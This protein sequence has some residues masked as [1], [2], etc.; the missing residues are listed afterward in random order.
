MRPRTVM[1]LAVLVA[2]LAAFIWFIER[3]L[4]GSDRRAE[5][6]KRVLAVEPDEVTAVV[7]E[8]GGER[9]RLERVDGR[10]PAGGSS[11]GEDEMEAAGGGLAAASRWA[12]VEPVAAPADA[13]EVDALVSALVELEKERTLDEADDAALGLDL[14][15]ARVV[16]ESASDEHTLLVGGEIPT[17]STMIVAAGDGRFVVSDA[18]W[19]D[20]GR[21]PG[22]WRSREVFDLERDQ[23][24]RVRLES[25]TVSLL[26]AR[27]G[28][29]F[30]IE[31]PE[32]DRAHEDRVSTLLGDLV[33]LE[34]DTFVDEP[35]GPAA[36]LGLE[37]PRATVELVVEGR[38]APLKLE[39]GDPTEDGGGRYARLGARLFE[40]GDELDEALSRPLEEWRSA[41][42][43]SL[44]SWEIDAA[45][46]IDAGGEMALTREGGDW[47]RGEATLE[48]TPV[49]DLL[50]AVT[51]AA[52]ER[53]IDRAE[54]GAELPEPTLELR[55]GGD[56][57]EEILRLHGAW[58]GGFLAS[59]EGRDRLLVLSAGTVDD[60]R[61]KLEGVRE[62]EPEGGD[63]SPEVG[64]TDETDASG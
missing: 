39:L 26:L 32:V 38:E 25:D 11:A 61:M 60:L 44:E 18:L 7:I 4:P 50:Y 12:V 17:S 3:D 22:D 56:D 45:T 40:L 14:P 63:D 2:A 21:A 20:L 23:I 29:S 57:R 47:K 24:E 51:G 10:P 46:A 64:P 48:Y 27:R 9:V 36:E 5:L 35:P 16:L 43:T 53:L 6:A 13:T 58:E 62:A 31:S 15:R 34:I 41:A 42:W 54:V 28:E 19:R 37:P 8:R 33:A 55:L 1:V 52:A 30:W 49:S 59:T